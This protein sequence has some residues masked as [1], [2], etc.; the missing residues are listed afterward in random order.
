M[1]VVATEVFDDLVEQIFQTSSKIFLEI[2]VVEEEAL[3]D[4]ALTIEDQI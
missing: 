3:E 1:V 4:V 2:L